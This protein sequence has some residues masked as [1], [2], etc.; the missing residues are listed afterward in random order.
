MQFMRFERPRVWIVLLTAV[1]IACGF[2]T[3][4]DAQSVKTI[5]WYAGGGPATPGD[6]GPATGAF[7]SA[8]DGMTVDAAGNLYIADYGRS[9]VRK[10]TAATGV[11]TTVAGTGTAG[12]TGDGGPATAAQIDTPMDVAF[13]AA[14]NLYISCYSGNRVRRV[15]AATGLITTVA[16]TGAIGYN[17]DG[18]PATAANVSYPWGI[19]VNAAGDLF[20][21]EHVHNRIRK[22]SASTGLIS[23]YAGTGAGGNSGDGGPATQGTIASVVGMTIDTAGNIYFA[24]NSSNIIRMVTAATGVIGTAA[25]TRAPGG[26]GGDGGLATEALLNMPFDV[27]VDPL[28]ILYIADP[29]NERI[30]RVVL[31]TGIITTWAGDG[32]EGYSG[33]GGPATAAQLNA[34]YG[35]AVGRTGEVYISDQGSSPSKV[36]RKVTGRDKPVITWPTP[37]PIG[38]G[39]ALSATQLNATASVAGTF[40]YDPPAGTVLNAGA[41]QTLSVA[42]T[43]DDTWNY[44]ATT[45]TVSLTVT[46]AVP[47]I[48]WTDPESIVYGT[49]LSAAQLNALAS[50][51]GAFVYS[52]PAGTVLNGGAGQTLSTTFTPNDAANYSTATATVA[53]TVTKATPVITWANPAP[54]SSS[55]PLSATQLNATANV[56]GTFVYTPPAGTTLSLGAGQ[57]LSTVF[58]PT[59]SGNY[60]TATKQVTIDVLTGPPTGPPYRLTITPPTGGKVTGAGI[61]CGAGGTACAVTMPVA[62]TIGITATPSTGYTFTS[63]SGDCSGTAAS[64]SVNLQGAR[65]CAATFTPAGGG[66]TYALTIAP[67]PTGGTVTGNGLTCGAGGATCAVTFGSSTTATLTATPAS[68]YTFTSWGG[69]CSGTAATT[70]VLVD[71]AKS[72]SATFTTSGGGGGLPTGPPYRLTITPPTGGKVTGAGINCGAGGT[73]CAVTMPVAMT[74]GMT[75]TASSGYTFTGWSGDCS[76]TAASISVN[77][78]G[79]RTCAATFTAAG[80][81]ATYALT[82]APTPTGGTVTGNGLTCGAGG[83]TCAVTFGSSTTATLTATPAS[84]YTFTSWGGACSGTS[85]TT[86]VLVDGAKS[87]S[88]TFT[89]SGGGGGLPTGPPYTLTITPPTGGKVTGAGI[90]CGAGGTACAV[91]MPV[92]MTLGMTATPSTGY[93]FT[94]WSGDCSGTVAVDL[95]Q[96]AGRA[97]V[98]GDVLGGGRGRDLRA[99]DCADADG[100][101]G[102]GE[103][104][105]V[106]RGRRD[107]RGD[108]GE[109]DDGDADGDTGQRL[110]VHELGRGLQRDGG[111]DQRAGGCGEELQRDVHGERGRRR[112]ADRAAVQADDHAADGREGDGGGDQLR[113]GRHRVRGDDA[114]G[115]DAGDPGDGQQRV[116]VHGLVGRLQRDRGIDFGQL[117]GRADVRRHV[118]GGGRHR[119]F[120]DHSA[121]ADGRDGD[122]ERADVRRGRRDVRGDVRKFDDGDADGGAG[123]GVYVHQLGRGVQWDERDDQRAGGCGEE[124]QCDVHGE[125]GRRRAANGAAVYADDH[126]ADGRESDGGRD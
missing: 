86:S 24:Q 46:K 88:A 91:T 77:L 10:V 109:R 62:M 31:S 83:A 5:S 25:G 117:A 18:I 47:V 74:L 76:G 23:T 105:D 79:A 59:N 49:A 126:A 65:T 82:I 22:V 30:R 2:T 7:L 104:A 106:R 112:A 100:R 20:I 120:A 107:V 102:G 80:G 68:G 101:D 111:D 108:V 95:G 12:Y 16:G 123:V 103:R 84:G 41:G 64:I 53:L 113:R 39:T 124:L 28:G 69:A 66:A 73:A 90:S 8:V 9:V 97:D 26:F 40:V 50:V 27:D 110:H 96:L 55:T 85:A 93:T 14:G 61:N 71:A 17:G 58:T 37:A 114:G 51:V 11:I 43:P 75:A 35:L 44:I 52:P 15:S 13:D 67:T 81:G 70:S 78:Q 119:L 92:A 6:G 38:Y 115:D 29:G 36:I 121:H 99:D 32:T 19:A 4:A 94:S 45:A 42:F 63:W 116:Y 21:A 87:C 125:R 60:T 33:D 48:V 1:L 54:I 89:A 57:T 56:P 72:C 118:H 122:G 34:P 3:R 98:R